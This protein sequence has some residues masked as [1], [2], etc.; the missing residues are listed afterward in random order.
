MLEYQFNEKVFM[1][2]GHI[3]VEPGLGMKMI[4]SFQEWDQYGVGQPGKNHG[5]NM[6]SRCQI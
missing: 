5:V 4:I 3:N 6:I 1:I 2:C